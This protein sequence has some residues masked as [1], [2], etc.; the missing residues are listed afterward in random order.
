MSVEVERALRIM[1]ESSKKVSADRSL[2]NSTSLETAASLSAEQS[3]SCRPQTATAEE[4][5]K[6][7]DQKL[8]ESYRS[9]IHDYILKGYTQRVPKE[10]LDVD[11]KPQ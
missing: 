5:S 8:F 10:E 2:P 3:N 1:E 4:V 11:G 7:C 9:T 6:V